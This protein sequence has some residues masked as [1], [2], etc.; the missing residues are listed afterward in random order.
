MFTGLIKE[1]GKVKR[2][3]RMTAASYRLDVVCAG[4][5]KDA[6]LGDSISVNGVCLTVVSKNK[7]MLS[8]DVIEETVLRTALSGL[9]TGDEVN[10]EPALRSGDPIGGHFVQGHVD[11]VGKIT[12]ISKRI[13]QTVFEI[14][15]D[16]DFRN[17]IVEK[18][19]I[20]VD[21]ISLTVGEVADNRFKVYLIPHTLN[22]TTL[23]RS[24]PGGRVN[25]EFDMIGKYVSKQVS[26]SRR[27]RP[28]DE[29]LLKDAGF[30]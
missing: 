8:F 4:A 20:A 15:F 21:G 1:L 5:Y 14:E 22:S 10:I 17:F 28:L 25:L 12:S 3:S 16:Q 6:A 9:A 13:E 30:I 23:G 11:C 19:A 29:N 26:A 24:R 7:E 18:G 27:E 2:M